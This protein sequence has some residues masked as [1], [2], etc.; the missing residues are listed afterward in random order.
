MA[1]FEPRLGARPAVVST[2]E[3]SE[4]LD[5]PR[6]VVVD[7]RSMAAYNGWR[8]RGEARGGHIPGSAALPRAWFSSFADAEV[9]R[10]L[11]ERGVTADRTIVVCGD[12]ADDAAD[13]V[14]TLTRLGYEDVW[15][16][17]AG[18]SAWAA[19]GSRPIERLPNYEMLVHPEWLRRLME[20]ER[21]ESYGG[22]DY[23]LFHVNF[24]A[25]EEY[26]ESHLPG[27]LHLDTN[28]LEDPA[29]WNRRGVDELRASLLALGIS[30]DAT[31]ILYGRDSIRH[32]GEK[33]PG[34]RVGQL[35]ATRAA[36]ILHYA[37][38]RD[39]RVLDGGYDGWVLAGNPVETVVRHPQAISTFGGEIPQRPDFIVDIAE[40]KSILASEDA[41]LVSVRSWR[42]Q[43]GEA[44][45]YGY[46]A[47]GGRIPGDVWGGGG[48][49]AYQMQHYRNV[50]NTMRA[51]PEIAARWQEC[52]VTPDRRVAFYCGTGWRA[53]EAWFCA[54]L[55][56]WQR[57]AVYDGGWLEWAQDPSNPTEVGGESR[58][59]GRGRSACPTGFAQVVCRGGSGAAGRR[60][61]G[62]RPPARRF[63]PSRRMSATTRTLR[64]RPTRSLAAKKQ[65]RGCAYTRRLLRICSLTNSA[66]RADSLARALAT[67]WDEW[68]QTGALCASPGSAPRSRQ[69]VDAVVCH[70][71]Q[72]ELPRGRV[73]RQRRGLD[74]AP[75]SATQE[76]LRSMQPGADRRSTSRGS[77]RCV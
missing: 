68:R 20:G 63:G 5:D 24:G 59:A 6:L 16:Y 8:L 29:N 36:L 40:A 12:G 49:D 77:A 13:V 4:R 56:G 55:M 75:R 48:S 42:E 54:L 67:G 71:R 60:S 73:G 38:V 61:A 21:P 43:T 19:D 39:V 46:I 41:V 58:V 27:A 47:R 72:S 34:R 62:A 70:T 52:A 17:E 53:S 25:L 18:F 65:A 69:P 15:I 3:L 64:H 50:D 57:I 31:V 35:A 37:G 28:Q 22:N 14:P 33:A 7:V 32:A 76:A 44:S 1:M 2:G 26:R 51:Y 45:G 74:R 10:L 66:A 9:G 23:L 30:A 11:R